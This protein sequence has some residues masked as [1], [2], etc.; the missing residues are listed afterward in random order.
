MNDFDE[1]KNSTEELFGQPE[2]PETEQDN[3]T[4]EETQTEEQPSQ[5]QPTAEQALIDNAT[6]TAETAAQV[7]S[8]KDQ[9]LQQAMAT[10]EAMQ[11]QNEAMQGTIDELSKKNEE[12]LIEEALAPPTI[13]FNALAFADEETI[14]QAQAKY[15]QDMSEY[16]RQAL[17]REFAPVIE[18][19]NEAKANKEKDEVITGLSQIPELSGICDMVPQL[20][21][22]I[23]NNPALSADNVPMDE[24]YI[25]A[26]AIARGVN[27]I[28]TPPPQPKKMTA[29]DFIKMYNENPEFQE[30]IEKQRVS[31]VQNNQQVPIFSASSG[32]VNAALNIPEKPKTF[33]DA[34]ER[35]RQ[36]FR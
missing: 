28:N 1:A 5:E 35:T 14:K 13:D 17:M 11:K 2:Q 19:A 27:A 36:M 4:I 23:A 15:A 29:E 7:A 31:Q 34:S 21:K 20:D 32:A 9:Q 26:Y 10:I 24:K 33:D 12:N 18:Q 3:P 30:A 22:I 8:E 25:T 16:T 6:Q